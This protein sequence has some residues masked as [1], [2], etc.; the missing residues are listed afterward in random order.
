MLVT[1]D[2]VPVYH[3]EADSMASPSPEPLIILPPKQ[4]VVV[5][6]CVDVKHYIIYKVELADGRIGYIN[7][8]EYDLVRGGKPSYCQVILYSLSRVSLFLYRQAPVKISS[9][10]SQ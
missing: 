6:E 5:K 8:G 2:S 10:T 1:K 7:A 3:S 4:S 9:G